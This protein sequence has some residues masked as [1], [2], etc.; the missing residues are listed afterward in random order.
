M[1]TQPP[2]GVEQTDADSCDGCGHP[3]SL[4]DVATFRMCG[5]TVTRKAS[6]RL[7]WF[8]GCTALMDQDA[9]DALNVGLK[10]PIT[11]GPIRR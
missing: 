11:R 7:A 8:C 2:T 3:K 9:F 6:D 5:Q 4:H 10:T 1:S